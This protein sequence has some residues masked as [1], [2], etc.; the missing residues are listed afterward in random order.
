MVQY[1]PRSWWQVIF[2]LE[3]SV[4]P[5][6]IVRVLLAA[7]VGA[8]AAYFFENHKFKLGAVTHTLVGAALGLLLV[9]RT[10]ASFDRWWEGRKLLGA[11]V[12][13]TR[14]LTRQV[15]NLVEGEDDKTNM[16]RSRLQKLVALFFA[17]TGQ[18]LRSERELA[19]LEALVRWQHPE[20]GLILPDDFIGVAEQSGLLVPIG[21]WAIAQAC[22]DLRRLD[23]V[24]GRGLWV[25]VNVSPVQFS[26]VKLPTLLATLR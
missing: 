18:H 23:E 11:M 25:S 8:A 5:R 16:Q 6:L 9:F 26:A 13:R 1:N 12:N 7:A 21:S 24:A 17:V 3:G 2:R 20:R 14:D 15:V 10:N 4:L 19:K 22:A